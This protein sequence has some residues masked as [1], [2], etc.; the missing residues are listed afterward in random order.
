LTGVERLTHAFESVLVRLRVPFRHANGCVPERVP[1]VEQ[2]QTFVCEV[3][4]ERVLQIVQP[5]ATRD[6]GKL[7]CDVIVPVKS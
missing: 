3:A 1:D 6:P 7:L 4:G 5:A 2:R